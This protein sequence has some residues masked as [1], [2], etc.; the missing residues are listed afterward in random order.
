MTF[1][2]GDKGGPGRLFLVCCL[3]LLA[4]ACTSGESRD[5]AG[6]KPA[7]TV[8]L[9]PKARELTGRQKE[10]L[11]FPQ[12]IIA[13]VEA[14]A[15]SPAEPFFADVMM[16]SSNLKGDV[17]IA[18]S[19]LSGFSVRTGK[20]DE[21]IARLSPSL[22]AEGFLVFRSQHNFGS[23]PDVVTVV[24]GATSY[25]ILKI[26]KTEAPRRRLDTGAIIT[27]LRKQQRVGS[28]MVTGAGADWLEASF[29]RPPKDM[30]AFARRVAAFAPDVLTDHRGRID[31]L[32]KSMERE[33][34][35][36]LWWD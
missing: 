16:R 17:M 24:R 8:I 29:V 5:A 9:K 25:D 7:P 11:G 36:S 15:G 6:R 3:V 26:Q 33:N 1:V 28:F 31:D 22:R 32:A 35:F 18:G 19:R 14:A 21:L 12:E 20:A 27:W 10:K 2:T 13:R 23:V 34:G 30:N 4:A